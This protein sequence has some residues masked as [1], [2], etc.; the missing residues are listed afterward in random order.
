RLEV[1]NRE[2]NIY[3]GKIQEGIERE[4]TEEVGIEATAEG[5][6]EKIE[7]EEDNSEINLQ[8]VYARRTVINKEEIDSILG[9]AGSIIIYNA[10]T[11]EIIKAITK[12]TEIDSSGN[13]VVTYP[14]DVSRIRIVVNNPEKAGKINLEN[15]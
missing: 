14:E 3:K 6:A 5:I 1:K 4:I 12:N 8:N 2:D 11:S 9:E 13:I 15:V 7:I 10:D